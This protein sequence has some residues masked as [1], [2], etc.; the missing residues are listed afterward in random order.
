VIRVEIVP[1]AGNFKNL[2]FKEKIQKNLQKK[3]EKKISKN[4]F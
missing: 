1:C 4:F 2:F 3:F